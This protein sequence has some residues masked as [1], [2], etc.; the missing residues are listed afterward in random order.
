MPARASEPRTL[1]AS[2]VHDRAGLLALFSILCAFTL[3]TW[4]GDELAPRLISVLLF[5]LL[6]AFL[7]WPVK[8]TFVLGVPGA[9]LL[10]ATLYVF[11]Q[12]L[13]FPQKIVADGWSGVLFWF[14]AAAITCLATQVLRTVR[15]ASDFRLYFIIFGTGVCVLDL[16]EQASQTSKYFWLIPSRY[17]SVFGPFA[18]WNNFAQF[19]EL[20]LPL[21][22]WRALSSRRPGV[23]YLLCASV[24]VG[25]VVA[26]GSRAGTILVIVELF[27]VLAL[28]VG[29]NPNRTLLLGAGLAVVFSVL[30]IYAAGFETVIAKLQQS[31]QLTV[32]RNIDKSSLAM[33]RARPLN[34]WGLGTYVS[35]YRQ[36]ARYDD[37]TYVN[38]A[39][40]DWLQWAA[41]GGVFFFGIMLAMIVWSIRPAI[42]SVWGLGLIAVAIPALVDYPFA[43]FGVC[44]WYFCLLGMLAAARLNGSIK[45]PRPRLPDA[46]K[47]GLHPA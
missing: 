46:S 28:A 35:V 34:G 18:Y 3:T 4:D 37:G 25:A 26:S 43:R 30:F 15:A 19:V 44:G 22:L 17:H 21:T 45:A 11:L 10:L 13:F 16:L 9:C 42:H 7:S 41:E 5:L 8:R 2:T 39:H 47:F 27:A 24:Q 12:T 38:R 40:N 32:R 33:I 6:A 14:A 23:Q 1:R 29:R 20:L 36:F 31:D